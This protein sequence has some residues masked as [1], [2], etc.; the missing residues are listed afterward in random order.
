MAGF[1]FQT[2]F[3]RWKRSEGKWIGLSLHRHRGNIRKSKIPFSHGNG[4]V[5]KEVLK[6]P[7][8]IGKVKMGLLG[9][10]TF[11]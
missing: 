6:V 4:K 3:P 11:F 5:L 1:M 9:F 10:C 7:G 8:A 2:F